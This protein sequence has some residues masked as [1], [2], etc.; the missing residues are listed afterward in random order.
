MLTPP[1][2]G[3][4]GRWQYYQTYNYSTNGDN[5]GTKYYSTYGDNPGTKYY[6]IYNYST[7]GDNPGTK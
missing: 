3:I 5:P 2:N 1:C 6:Q 4:N 7:Y